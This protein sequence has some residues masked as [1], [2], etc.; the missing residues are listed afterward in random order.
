MSKPAPSLKA[1]AEDKDCPHVSKVT[2]F[3]VD[4][5][6][7]QFEEGF[8]LR[9]DNAD[10]QA[11]IDRLYS[12][13]KAGA[14]IPPVDVTVCEGIITA[15]DGHCRTRA[16]VR[17]RQEIPDYTLECRQLRGNDADAVLHMLGTGSGG[18]PLTPLEQGRGYLRLINMGLKAS[19]IAARLGVSRV[20]ID[21]G[22]TLAEAPAEVQQMIAAGE[23]SSTTARDAVKAGKGAV[24]ALRE[25]VKARKENPDAAKTPT[26]K[27]SKKKKVTAA[28]LKGTA[29]DKTKKKPAAK[30]EPTEKPELTNGDFL[31]V[32]LT[33]PQAENL[34]AFLKDFAGDDLK[35][36]AS[37]IELMLV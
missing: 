19:D 24:D 12:A 31:T 22:L 17:L 27:E 36:V 13:M 8:N 26:G 21:N 32:K 6:L 29:A 37:D 33:R 23:V 11:H 3:R 16:A 14:F 1:L 25:A 20:T 7:I 15:R 2:S 35:T 18:K 28:T 30:E 5:T 10:T 9:E 34:V 4:P